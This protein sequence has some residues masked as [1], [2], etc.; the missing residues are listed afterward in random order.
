[1]KLYNIALSR[2]CIESLANFNASELSQSQD[3]NPHI[4]NPLYGT[5]INFRL[6]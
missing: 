3:Q 2:Y 4:K 1:M 5:Y 6:V